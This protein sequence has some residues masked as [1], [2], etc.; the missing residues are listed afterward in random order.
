MVGGD[1]S[2]IVEA[3]RDILPDGGVVSDRD[4]LSG[5]E[6]DMTGRFAGKARALVRPQSTHEVSL[7]LEACS[8][9]AAPLVPQ[10]GNTGLVGGG[11]PGDGE[12]ILTLRALDW[13][14]PVDEV[15]NHVDVGA[16]ATLQSV[17]EHLAG[18]G[19]WLPIDHAARTAATIGGMVATDAGGPLA[20]R[21]GTMRRRVAGLEAVLAD[22]SV[23]SR[24]A[25]L[26]KDNAGY[27]L[28][29]LLTGSEGTLGVITAVRLQLEPVLPFRIVALFG[30]DGLGQAL[31]LLDALRQV[32][33]VQAADHFDQACMRLVR[34]HKGLTDPFLGPHPLYMVVE[35]A[36]AEDVTEDLAMA[37]DTLGE[38]VAVAAATDSAGRERLWAYREGLN[39]SVR[40][41]GV[42]HKLDVGVPLAAIP[43]FDRDVRR[44]IG[45]RHPSAAVYIYGH[46][47]DG[48]IHVNVVGPH[49]EDEGVDDLVLRC[50]AEYAGTISAEHGIGRAKRDYLHLSRS[51]AEIEAMR[52]LK[53]ALDPAGILAPGRVFAG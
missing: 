21:Y 9:D 14:G 30:L 18:T 28:P 1:D 11:V 4:V 51:L 42:P 36:A 29:A 7:A 49:P 37:A 32:P 8:R 38:G 10:G 12:L 5:F 35:C 17:H 46:I 31:D 41:A 6:Q 34:G 48:N 50:A 20:L 19:L 40:A 44:R 13:L 52:K 16:G 25:G 24:M 39:E 33:G 47:G 26:L 23:V 27:D 3:L 15:A 53:R 2:R 43:D 22:G 45:R